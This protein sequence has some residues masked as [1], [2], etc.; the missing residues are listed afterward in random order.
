MKK[1]SKFQIRWNEALGIPECPYLHRWVITFFGYSI[2]LHKWSRSDDKRHFHDHP[3]HFLTIVLKGGYNNV[4]PDEVKPLIAPS[5]H[6]HKATIPHYVEVLPGGCWTLLFCLKPY[7]KWGFWI[8]KKLWRPL[9]YF[10][11]FGHPP[12]DIL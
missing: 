2:R 8:N 5:I 3:F 4:T 11:K 12:C 10:S 6:W 7:R 9:R 1:F